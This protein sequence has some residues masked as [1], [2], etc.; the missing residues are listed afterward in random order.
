MVTRKPKKVVAKTNTRQEVKRHFIADLKRLEGN[1]GWHIV[2][3]PFDVKSAFGKGGTVPVKG[4]VNGFA[5]RTS[6]FPRK[7]GEHFLLVNKQ[8]QK[9]AGIRELGDSIEVEMQL[10]SEKR[11]VDIPSLLKEE[12]AEEPEL[13][14]YFRSFSY[15]MRKY[16]ADHISQPKNPAIRQRRARELAEVLLQMKEGEEV[17]PPILAAEFAHNPQA[18]KGW[19]LSSPSAKRGHLWGIHYYKPGEARDRRIQKA[20]EEMVE[21]SKRKEENGS[22]NPKEPVVPRS[23]SVKK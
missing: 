17:P 10:D 21:F 16:F 22:T 2:D 12:L 11:S 5:F 7:D 20:I 6:V 9:G 23:R 3:V 15:S 8:M 18:R 4:T 14:A 19:E 13:L 1:L